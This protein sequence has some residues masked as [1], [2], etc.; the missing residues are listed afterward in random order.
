MSPKKRGGDF[1]MVILIILNVS[2][3]RF[4]GNFQRE[5]RRLQQILFLNQGFF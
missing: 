4:T 3:P 2:S 5:E 1:E